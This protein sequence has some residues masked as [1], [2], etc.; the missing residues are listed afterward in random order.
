MCAQAA[1]KP[2]AIY[3]AIAANLVIAVAKFIAGGVT[4]SSAMLSEGV[5]SLVDTGNGLLLLLGR[6]RSARPADELHP[7]G[8]GKELYFWSLVVAVVLFGLGGGMSVWEGISHLMHPTEIGDPTWNYVVLGIAFLAEGTSW[9]I[10]LRELH[11]AT[12]IANPLR[13]AKASKD[14]SVYTVVGEDTAALAGLVVAFLGVFL[15]HRLQETW[16]DGAASIVIGLILG[17]VAVFLVRESRN[18]LVGESADQKVVQRIREIAEA[19]RAVTRV[20]RALTLHFGPESVLL[21][22]DLEFAEGV[23]AADLPQVIDRLER[24]IRDEF[25]DIHRIFIEVG[26]FTAT[27]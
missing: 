22:M 11:H 24:A 3:G 9:I 4:G 21:N 16:L 25:P 18:L 23:A 14:P 26:S 6:H 8:H 12:G 10:A 20:Q 27:T 13:A 19:D 7:F 2:I 5:H 15:G 1:K 17:T